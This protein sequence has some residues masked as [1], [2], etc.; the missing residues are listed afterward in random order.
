MQ[1][2]LQT[3]EATSACC[4]YFLKTLNCA[5]S[6]CTNV[7]VLQLHLTQS[8]CCCEGVAASLNL[9]RDEQQHSHAQAGPS[10][11]SNRQPNGSATSDVSHSQLHRG[12]ANGAEQE[13]GPLPMLASAC[14]GWV[15]YAEKTHGS[16]ILPYISTTKS[17]QVR[18]AH[19]LTKSP[20]IQPILTIEFELHTVI[21]Q[22]A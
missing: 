22:H 17:P 2:T 18:L 5:S 11:A 4:L 3:S 8:R 7:K 1:L 20:S 21:Q 19:T 6:A 9:D 10:D 13:A 16:Y 12:S 14:P 15:C